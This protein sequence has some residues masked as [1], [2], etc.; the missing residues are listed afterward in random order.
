[1]A[2]KAVLIPIRY[3]LEHEHKPD[4]LKVSHALNPNNPNNPYN[5]NNPNNPNNPYK[6]RAE[7]DRQT[8]RLTDKL[9]L[10]TNIVCINE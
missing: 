2:R 5:P 3:L 8:D 10:Y 1:M 7:T 4:S 9:S 6:Q